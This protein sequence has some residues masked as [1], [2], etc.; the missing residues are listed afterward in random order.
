MSLRLGSWPLSG[1]SLVHVCQFH[2]LARDLLHSLG[3][4]AHK[5]SL[6]L[7]GWC[8]MQRE[9]VSQ[10]IHRR[11][12]L[13]TLLA[14]RPVVAAPRAAL[15]RGLQGAGVQYG[16]PRIG[17]F[18]LRKSQEYTQIVDRLLERAPGTGQQTP[19]L[20]RTRRLGMVF[21]LSCPHATVSGLKFITPSNPQ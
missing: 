19:T 11:V 20:R 14:L 12:Y 1:I 18:A 4:L 15:R 9:Q 5:L 3:Q 8:H 16:C 6:L 13:R 7:V 17:C 21:E 10:G 2:R